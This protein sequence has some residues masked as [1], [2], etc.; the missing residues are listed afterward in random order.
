[1]SLKSIKRR[2]RDV[3]PYTYFK[4]FLQKNVGNKWDDVY[5][6]LKQRFGNERDFKY[7]VKVYITKNVFWNNG[8]K[9]E[10]GYAVHGFYIHDNILCEN[11]EARYKRRTFCKYGIGDD[12]R[13][14]RIDGVWFRLYLGPIDYRKDCALTPIGCNY[15]FYKLMVLKKESLSKRDIQKLNLNQYNAD[16][17]CN[18]TIYTNGYK[19]GNYIHKETPTRW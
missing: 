18:I 2:H 15:V 5:S 13:Y 14:L 11:R 17:Y 12:I 16:P 10:Y 3:F 6:E 8:P 7:Y 19:I 1:M 9:T 4:R